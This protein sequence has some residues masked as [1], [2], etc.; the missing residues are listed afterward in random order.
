M[1]PQIRMDGVKKEANKG[2]SVS[3]ER[4]AWIGPHNRPWSPWPPG[5]GWVGHH[6][7]ASGLLSQQRLELHKERRVPPL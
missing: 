7:W 2:D 1:W 4:R 6:L 5:G 3:G